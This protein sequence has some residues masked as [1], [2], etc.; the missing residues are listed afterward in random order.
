[1]ADTDALPK[2]WCVDWRVEVLVTLSKT[3]V[4]EACE[5]IEAATKEEAVEK[6]KAEMDIALSD[7]DFSGQI[8]TYDFDLE[9]DEQTFRAERV[10]EYEL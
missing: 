1:M 2:E 9:V 8:E 5:I 6:A 10:T 3:V 4:H 7:I